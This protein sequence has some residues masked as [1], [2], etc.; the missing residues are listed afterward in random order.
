[1]KAR[2]TH[3]CGISAMVFLILFAVALHGWAAPVFTVHPVRNQIVDENAPV[4]FT[5]SANG[6][7]ELNYQ[8]LRNGLPIAGA[9]GTTL[10][11]AG[12]QYPDRGYYQVKVA[13]STGVSRSHAGF[14]NVR[15][16]NEIV[17]WSG[18]NTP[19]I[20]APVGPFDALDIELGS[21][22]TLGVRAWPGLALKSDGTVVGWN[23]AAPAPAGLNDVVSIA[24]GGHHFLALKSDGTVVGWKDQAFTYGAEI[25]PA[26]L[27]GVVAIAAGS[28]SSIALKEDGKV[29]VWGAEDEIS[30]LPAGLSDIIAIAAGTAQI[31]ALRS[32]GTVLSWGGGQPGISVPSGLTDVIAIAAGFRFSLALKSDGTVVGWG[33]NEFGE[34]TIPPGLAGVQAIAAGDVHSVALKADGTV[35]TWGAQTFI[36]AGLSRV[37]AIDAGL[38]SSLALRRVIP[39]VITVQPQPDYQILKESFP[40]TY[41]VSATG[42]GLSY[43]WKKDGILIAGA[44]GA[45]FTIGRT[46]SYD[47]GKYSVTVTNSAG[48]V[49]SNDISLTLVGPTFLTAPEPSQV[50][51]LDESVTLSAATTGTGTLTYQ[52]LHNGFP[53]A[54]ATGSSLTLAKAQYADRGY[55]QLKVTDSLGEAI[56]RAGFLNVLVPGTLRAWGYDPYGVNTPPA[57]LLAVVAFSGDYGRSLALKSDGTVAAWGDGKDS[58]WVPAG[59]SGVVA[60]SCKTCNVALKSD[61]SIVA[62]KLGAY[63]E[64]LVFSGLSGVVAVSEQFVLK[65][66]GTIQSWSFEGELPPA[67]PSGASEIVAISTDG[68]HCL[69]LKADRTV[70][71]TGSP[72]S[73]LPPG[74]S[75]V[76]AIS[77]AYEY[78]LAVK[79]DGSV[80]AWG[81]NQYGQTSVPSGLSG[82]VAVSAG[83]YHAVAL[84]SDGSVA[85]WGSPPSGSN[86]GQAT[87]PANLGYVFDIEAGYLSNLALVIP[88]PTP[89]VTTAAA[90]EIHSTSATFNAEIVPNGLPT[91]VYFQ[92]RTGTLAYETITSSQQAGSGNVPVKISAIAAN[93]PAD[94]LLYYRAVATNERLTIYGAD[95]SF[96]TLPPPPP[97][98]SAPS[99]LAVTAIE[100]HTAAATLSG[101]FNPNGVP[102]S[103]YFEYRAGSGSV[104]QTDAQ[105]FGAGNEP[106]VITQAISGLQGEQVYQFRLV[107]ANAGGITYS[108][109]HTFSTAVNP[110]PTVATGTASLI[111]TN[112][113]VLGSKLNPNGLAASVSFEYGYTTSYGNVTP[114]QNIGAGYNDVSVNAIVSE[115]S[116]GRLVHFRAV[117]VN[118]NGISYGADQTFMTAGKK[119]VLSK[120]FV[121]TKIGEQKYTITG[122]C[123][124][125]G[126][127]TKVHLRIQTSSSVSG[128]DQ[129]IG[130]G[131]E[132]VLIS[133]TVTQYLA[134]QYGVAASNEAG[135]DFVDVPIREAQ[136]NSDLIV[137]DV[138]A[139]IRI[140]V[141][142]NDSVPGE[143]TPSISAVTQGGAGAVSINPDQSL[144]Y[145]PG[146]NFHGLDTFTYTI[147]NQVGG[148][149]TA[150]VEVRDTSYIP[151]PTAKLKAGN[152][153]GLA[154][155]GP[156]FHEKSV[157]I[158]VTLTKS[159]A[160]S[161]HLQYAG[162]SYPIKGSIRNGNS[163]TA[164]IGPLKKPTLYVNFAQKENNGSALS[165][166]ISNLGLT[167]DALAS[168]FTKEAPCTLPG[169]FTATLPLEAAFSD[170][171]IPQAAGYGL[172]T[173]NRLGVARLTGKL[174]DGRPVSLASIVSAQYELPLYTGLYAGKT[175]SKG[176]LFGNIKFHTAATPQTCDGLLYWYK[177]PQP[178][179][180]SYPAGFTTTLHLAGSPYLPS[181]PAFTITGVQPNADFTI[182]GGNLEVEINKAVSITAAYRVGTL[183]PGADHLTLR[184][185]PRTGLFSGSFH[186]PAN[187][188]RRTFSG[189]ILQHDN[190]GTGLFSG[191]NETGSVLLMPRS[192][193]P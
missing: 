5:A 49:T 38:Y 89:S 30:P 62:W 73:T 185:V 140:D 193:E 97:P 80:V 9:N 192:T 139:A 72:Y 88:I 58:E 137:A 168:S 130:S 148:F 171:A 103:A 57:G 141:L 69:A 75:G 147:S 129:E 92:L 60:I 26:G 8:W 153:V 70:L 39:P 50:V 28:R 163:Y 21:D 86:G 46:S 157:Y 123:N 77:A 173:L 124:P 95:Q 17:T 114:A 183:S 181:A 191:R 188:A 156:V 37:L 45:S 152:Y 47:S 24:A 32:D 29:V 33:Y 125:N 34:A 35:V 121:V 1:M 20:A 82:V 106:V 94:K 190:L 167:F 172:I 178:S 182:T 74:L 186:D 14:L 113:T 19:S 184:V 134:T 66:D 132:P 116:D 105:A 175:S 4:T 84:K 15:V 110:I 189:V 162:E 108:D 126:L 56:S 150:M 177:P 164:A 55:Y 7:G 52:W 169:R 2:P 131:F 63:A 87:V 36:P 180:K 102:A 136:A 135:A 166:T 41:S 53:I 146:A 23:G 48:S 22:R 118:A 151:E 79:S 25:V 170:P 59:L 159:A 142:G 10:T 155:A 61:G 101:T 122:T 96:K 187:H 67:V 161:G 11:L 104:S 154:L 12:V 133:F 143:L 119:P 31:L 138:T 144:Q 109:Y 18:Y 165:I 42:G 120:P 83:V 176:S 65:S 145:S 98:P 16:H 85:V 54:G 112:T 107:S 174:G 91:S 13:D 115:L 158:R 76:N 149:S 78:S 40:V 3:P 160:F 44:T 81:S 51:N 111:A 99:V 71:D 43:Q 117:A 90:T 100:V 27:S 179:D 127:A 64:K 68:S 93:L 6:T 128:P